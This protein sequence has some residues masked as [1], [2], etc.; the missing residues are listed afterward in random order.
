MKEL[1]YLALCCTCGSRCTPDLL[2]SVRLQLEV[3][4]RFLATIH[5]GLAG[6]N[7]QSS[8]MPR[9]ECMAACCH[10]TAAYQGLW[11]S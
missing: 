2:Q 8:I 5:Q 7:A 10:D 4:S 3:S 11:R 1:A 9:H 6:L